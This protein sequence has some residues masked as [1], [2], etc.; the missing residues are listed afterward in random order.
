[1]TVA[2]N[3]HY[4]TNARSIRGFAASVQINAGMFRLMLACL[5]KPSQIALDETSI[6]RLPVLV[7]PV[8][9]H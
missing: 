9:Y 3:V 2:T 1:M 7:V 5:F 8:A 6:V 4:V